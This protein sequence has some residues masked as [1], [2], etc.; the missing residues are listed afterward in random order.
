MRKGAGLWHS[1]VA[2][3]YFFFNAL[4][5]PFGMLYTHLMSPFFYFY[6]LVKRRGVVLFPLFVFL[7]P[8]SVAHI[9]VGVKWESF[10]I[11]NGLLISTYI[12]ASTFAY[13]APRFLN[14][15]RIYRQLLIA[16]FFFALV[17][18]G[19]LFTPWKELVWYLEKFTNNIT[20][21][22]RLAMLTYE[23]SYYSF[24]FAPIALYYL[25]KVMM[26]QYTM[27]PWVI[28][29]MVLVPLGLSLSV[30][31]I[32]SMAIA[33]IGLFLIHWQK[34]FYKR[35]F[36][37]FASLGLSVVVLGG[38]VALVFFPE[39]AV[40]V[41]I[42]NII[43]GRDSSALSRTVY[44]FDLA[45]L[46]AKEGNIWFGSGMGQIK[47]LVP[48]IAREYYGHYGDDLGVV[49]I[50]NTLAETLATFGILGV[51]LRFLLIFFFL[52]TSRVRA[53]Y[54]QTLMF[55]FVFVYQFTGSFIVN[56][57]EY[58]AWILAFTRVFPEFD[59]RP[60]QSSS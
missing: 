20:D 7:I 10:I 56:I 59:V 45:K 39:N 2:L 27:S 53:N 24:L 8:F 42:E 54:Y 46:V 58:V 19:L 49:R 57:V 43:T 29:I 35:T 21:L 12:V 31:I 51:A 36:F 22:P 34:I 28:L 16:N 18:V 3:I 48:K 4:W 6:L 13:A 26:R 55:I 41:R 1:I 5:L 52:Y 37:A 30:G 15:K 25:L 38:L 33:F 50:P 17:C 60:K 11:S 14:L 32:A 44:S 47:E 9:I 40:L 23:A